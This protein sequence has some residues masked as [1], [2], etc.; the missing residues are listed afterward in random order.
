MEIEVFGW[1][2]EYCLWKGEE[3]LDKSYR[4][5]KVQKKGILSGGMENAIYLFIYQVFIDPHQVSAPFLSWRWSSELDRQ[6]LY[7]HWIY[8]LLGEGRW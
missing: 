5:M 8:G 3:K 2:L 6:N 7:F 1:H 4:N